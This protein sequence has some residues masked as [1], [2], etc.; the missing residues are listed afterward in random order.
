V[1][2]ILGLRLKFR[3]SYKANNNLVILHK[4]D[5]TIVKY[6]KI[7]GLIIRFNGKNS[8]IELWEPCN[9]KGCRFVLGSNSHISIQGT[10]FPVK[11]GVYMQGNNNKLLIGKDLSSNDTE[12]TTYEESNNTVEIG[13]DCMFSFNIFLNATD[14]HCIYDINK[15]KL[16][17]SHKRGIKIGN[18]VW[19]G[20]YVKIL[21]NVEIPDNTVIGLGSI[22]TKSFDEQNIIIAGSPAKVIKRNIGWS[23][24]AAKDYIS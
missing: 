7:E 19:V 22:V 14:G 6:P 16:L 18:H 11:L 21:K 12:I 4:I 8:T 2:N 20:R 15:K 10:K 23:R 5:G 1:L 9:F 3:I 17:N 24:E 13:N